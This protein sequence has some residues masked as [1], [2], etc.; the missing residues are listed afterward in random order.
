MNHLPNDR[1][2]SLTWDDV[3]VEDPCGPGWRDATDPAGQEEA[4]P[5]VEGHVSQ[6]LSE[7]GVGV[8]RQGDRPTVLPDCISGHTG[9]T[10]CIVGLA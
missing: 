2:C 6:Q 3:V 8:N 10:A 1:S 5:L 9:V 7:D 4:F